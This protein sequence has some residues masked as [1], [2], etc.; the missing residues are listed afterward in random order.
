M[1]KT[2]DVCPKCGQGMQL[3][4]DED[5]MYLYHPVWVQQNIDPPCTNTVEFNND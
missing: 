4:W 3:N 5:P 1:A 2:F